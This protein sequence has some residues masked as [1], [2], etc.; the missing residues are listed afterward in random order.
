M[1][2]RRRL[3]IVLSLL[4]CL[5]LA[6]YVAW[7][8]WPRTAITR[9]NA[10]LIRQG[11]TVA[12]VEAILGGPARD[13]TTGPC[14]L[15]Y[16]E[17]AVEGDTAARRARRA[18]LLRLSYLQLNHARRR[19]HVWASDHVEVF[20]RVDQ[21]GRVTDCDHVPTR[22]LYQSPVVMLRRWLRGRHLYK[23]RGV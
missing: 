14:T 15:D 5:L 10:A 9:E 12:E 1:R 8:L 20:V 2:V 3:F 7:L 16:G 23:G 4:A 19:S 11:M 6:G 18:R 13:E 17:Q 21:A 22:R